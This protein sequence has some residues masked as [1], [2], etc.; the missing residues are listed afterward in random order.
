[1]TGDAR[2]KS[3]AGSLA[4]M[5]ASTANSNRKMFELNKAA[6]ITNAIINTYE[7]VTK[8]LA[9]YPPP[10]SFAMAGAQ[11]AAGMAQVSAELELEKK[12]TI[13]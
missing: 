11:L 3:I 12:K 8:A 13:I 7:G 10:I 5:T 4:E 9:S 6:G 2:V 1:M